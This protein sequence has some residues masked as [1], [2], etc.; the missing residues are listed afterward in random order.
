MVSDASG[1]PPGL[2]MRKSMALTCLSLAAS[3]KAPATSWALI[4]LSLGNMPA[5]PTFYRQSCRCHRSARPLSRPCWSQLLLSPAFH[6]MII[7]QIIPDRAACAASLPMVLSSKASFSSSS[8]YAS[9]VTSSALK[10]SFAV[11]KRTF[12]HQFLDAINI[13]FPAVGNPVGNF[14]PTD[15]RSYSAFRHGPAAQN[16]SRTLSCPWQIYIL[17]AG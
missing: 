14:D 2:S 1:D 12:G 4:S 7:V 16:S 13:P 6:G 15:H 17:R 9:L 11:G 8:A 3:S 5:G 10:H